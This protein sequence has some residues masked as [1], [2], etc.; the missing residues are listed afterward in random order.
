MQ[1]QD[2][3]QLIGY[4]ASFLVA[5]SMLMTSILRLRIVNLVGSTV[6]GIYGLLIHAY[7][8]AA[9][10]FFIA[11]INVVHVMRMR[12]TREFFTIVNVVPESDYLLF[13]LDRNMADIR[14]SQPTFV[15]SPVANQITVFVVRDLMP[16]GL[17]IGELQADG[18]LLVKLDYVIPGY[19]DLKIGKYLLEDR[20]DFF[21][22][23]GVTRIVTP[24]GT[25]MHVGYLE[26][27]GFERTDNDL[28]ARKVS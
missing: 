10:N 9:V 8:V 6:F 23:R 7:P 27:M 15:Y 17:F 14:K 4:I 25:S 5:L 26:Q 11:G 28:Y 3:Y 12:R 22:E 16:A 24:G 20:A 1:T 19:R 2:I 13:F 18:T 21:R